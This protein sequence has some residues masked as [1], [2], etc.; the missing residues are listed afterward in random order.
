MSHLNWEYWECAADRKV[1]R[2]SSVRPY[3]CKKLHFSFSSRYNSWSTTLHIKMF[4]FCSFVFSSIFPFPIWF[5]QRTTK[6]KAFHLVRWLFKLCED[7][8]ALRWNWGGKKKKNCLHKFV[9]LNAT[10][11]EKN[12]LRIQL[13]WL[14]T[15]E[16]LATSASMWC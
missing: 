7:K 10:G 11:R 8:S 12:K 6:S 2:I 16:Q 4:I 13:I 14:K 9:Q 1:I 3:T 5:V 15:E